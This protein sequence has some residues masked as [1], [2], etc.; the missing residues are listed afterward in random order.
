MRMGRGQSF[1][2]AKFIMFAVKN[3]IKL[4]IKKLNVRLTAPKGVTLVN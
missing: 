1:A 2:M 3:I 4:K